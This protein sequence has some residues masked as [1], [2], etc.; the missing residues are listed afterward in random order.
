M[1]MQ[2]DGSILKLHGDT[3]QG[4]KTFTSVLVNVIRG[5][6]PTKKSTFAAVRYWPVNFPVGYLPMPASGKNP[7][8]RR[9]WVTG[10]KLIFLDQYSPDWQQAVDAGVVQAG[11]FYTKVAKHFIKKYGWH[12]NRWTDSDDVQELDEATLDDEEPQDG[13][14]DEEVTERNKYFHELR[15]VRDL[16]HLW[17]SH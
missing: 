14:T 13:L 17:T 3:G 9:T 8:G 6:N 2:E 5:V 15:A 4:T 7:R 10:T 1:Y 16:Y 12:F 11:A